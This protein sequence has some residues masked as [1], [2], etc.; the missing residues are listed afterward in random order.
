MP[1]PRS[2]TRIPGLRSITWLKDSVSHRTFGPIMCLIVQSTSYF[3]DRGNAAGL[4]ALVNSSRF[5][6]TSSISKKKLQPRT[7]AGAGAWVQQELPI[8]QACS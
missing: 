1:Q 3:A 8:W 4:K 5:A 6:C 2:R 7:W